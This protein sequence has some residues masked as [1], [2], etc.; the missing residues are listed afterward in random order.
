[1]IATAKYLSH[2]PEVELRACGEGWVLPLWF[3]NE[4][5]ALRFAQ[6]RFGP[7]RLIVNILDPKGETTRVVHFPKTAAP[8]KKVRR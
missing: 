4:T 8:I 7:D 3:S 1:M 6:A 5:A 2:T